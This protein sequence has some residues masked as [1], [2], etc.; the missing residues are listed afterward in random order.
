MG[1]I[2]YALC[3]IPSS[4]CFFTGPRKITHSSL[5][6]L[7]W[8]AA[9]C[10]PLQPVLLLMSFPRSRSPM[11]GVPGL[12]WMWHGVPFVHQWRPLAGVLRLCWLWPGSFDCF[13]YPPPLYKLR[14]SPKLIRSLRLL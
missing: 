11:V 8:V 1:H 12:C 3:D 2:T 10:R 6:I 7:R 13:C 9:F 5:R 4:C 14:K